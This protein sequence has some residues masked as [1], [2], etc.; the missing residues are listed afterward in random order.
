[1]DGAALSPVVV[2]AA[3]E[4][5]LASKTFAGGGRSRDLLQY[6][7]EALLSGRADQL[8]EY[9]VGADGLGRGDTFD[10]RIDSIAR[11]EASRLRSRL[12]LYH[13]TEGREDSIVISLPT[14]GYVPVIVQRASGADAPADAG[15]M[16]AAPLPSPLLSVRSAALVAFGVFLAAAVF[17]LFQLGAGR[18]GPGEIAPAA[19]PLNADFALGTSGEISQ[20]A[21]THLAISRDGK[22]MVMVV[23][24]EGSTTRLYSRRMDSLVA[25]ELPGTGGAFSPF[26]SPDG[27]WVAFIAGSELKKTLVDG[28][29]SPVTLAPAASTFSGSWGED[30][31]I[32]VTR[33]GGSSLWRVP[34]AGGKPVLLADFAPDKRELRFP[35]LLPNQKGVLFIAATDN[36]G[37]SID[38]VRL[39]GTGRKTLVARG[40]NARYLRSGHILYSDGPQLYA[41][42]FDL[43]RAEVIGAPRL[44]LE[45]V[46]Y[47]EAFGATSFDV[48]DDGTLV[49]V[50]NRSGGLSTVELIDDAGRARTLVGEPARRIFPRI[51]P[52]GRHLAYLQADGTSYDLWSYD[53]KSAAKFK[54]SAGPGGASS[55][56]WSADGRHIFYLYNSLDRL[57]AML[58]DGSGEPQTLLDIAGNYWSASPDGKRLAFQKNT[59]G[60]HLDLWTLPIDTTGPS[61]KAGAPEFFY[62]TAATETQPVFSPDGAWLAHVATI[63]GET[64]IH[65]RHFPDNGFST[66][67]SVGGGRLAA[68]SRTG[69]YLFYETLDQR[70]MR[71]RYRIERSAF[72]PEKPE[73][74]M[75][76]KLIDM[77][78]LPNYALMPD[79]KSIVAF[80]PVGGD[81]SSRDHVT[82]MRNFFDQLRH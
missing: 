64:N 46:A 35:H 28:G 54:F 39:D 49:Y 52:D 59:P 2:R 76:G 25:T 67:V 68:W 56:A 26:L 44:V 48:A 30:G 31:Q 34:E 55:P 81:G 43:D 40:T 7:V 27:R 73:A 24:K 82:I 47:L 62:G 23:R 58:A 10:P 38:F 5:I 50:R 18:T 33:D 17:A 20:S 36:A 8:K 72:I 32:I 79:G 63:D 69:P 77:A 11:A 22:L 19:V 60:H 53:M 57:V 16:A 70:I 65:V 6:L 74:W 37:G 21:G 66:T 12:T 61:P 4:R 80:M 41:V 14:G 71:V 13:A 15:S 29:G 1:M 42:K 51:S 78:V 3:L 9:T 45:G 75:P